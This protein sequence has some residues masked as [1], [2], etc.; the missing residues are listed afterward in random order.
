MAGTVAGAV[1]LKAQQV[2]GGESSGI[3]E[4]SDGRTSMH[5]IGTPQVLELLDRIPGIGGRTRV[6]G[7]RSCAAAGKL[8]PVR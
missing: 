1:R 4:D 5:G 6:G 2:Y 8:R 3:P 7:Y